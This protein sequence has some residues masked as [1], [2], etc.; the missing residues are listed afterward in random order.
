MSKMATAPLT[1]SLPEEL[2]ASTPPE[3]RG[4]R[5]DHV[6]LMISDRSTGA[7]EHVRFHQLD[8]F[9]QPG[10]VVVLNSSRTIPAVLR[11]EDR[12]V[13]LA[14]RLSDRHWDA[15]IM[16]KTVQAGEKLIF[17]PALQA[18]VHRIKTPLVELRFSLSDACLLE[19]IYA[20]G[21]PIRYE[22][23]HQ[24][25]P[26]EYYQNVY[27][28]EPGSVE[29]PSAGRAFS[30]EVL[31]RL[32]RR[33]IH[34]AYLTLHTGLSY[35]SEELGALPPEAN[36][37][38]YHI[39]QETVER[40]SQAKQAGNRVIAVGTTVVR[41][42][43]SDWLRKAPHEAKAGWTCIHIDAHTPL[44]VVDGLMTGFHEPEASHLDLL[45]AFAPPESLR[46]MYEEAIQLRYLW[47][48][49][50]DIHLII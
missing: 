33:G 45:S 25:W 23:I 2:N 35:L 41:A 38:Y 31:F 19:Q 22:Y 46:R 4:L 21:E 9:L 34:V 42:L 15:F 14:R 18:E 27:A 16:G 37:E 1:F 20:L 32:K 48:E 7:S 3:R 10:D 47:H 17:S 50:G 8:Q 36:C 29:L 40:V 24:P 44:R 28:S 43:E 12:E 5:R 30:W 39:P 49:F 11:T 26:L 13:R 6:R